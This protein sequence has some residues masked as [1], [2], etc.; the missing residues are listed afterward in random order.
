MNSASTDHNSSQ[1]QQ[2]QAQ[3]DTDHQKLLRQKILQIQQDPTL[4]AQDKAK[5]VQNLLMSKFLASAPVASISENQVHQC[6]SHG[7]GSGVP[8][9][10]GFTGA[11]DNGHPSTADSQPTFHVSLIFSYFP[12]TSLV[13]RQLTIHYRMN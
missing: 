11:P 2:K 6:C 1:E 5:R 10:T 12:N 13:L 4:D 8:A 3:E 9:K 7:N